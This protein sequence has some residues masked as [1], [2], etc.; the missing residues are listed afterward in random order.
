MIDESMWI[1]P[2]QSLKSGGSGNSRENIE[3]RKKLKIE[4]QKFARSSENLAMKVEKEDEADRVKL[5]V[6]DGNENDHARETAIATVIAKENALDR[7]IDVGQETEIE[8]DLLRKT[9]N[10]G[11][12]GK[13]D[14]PETEED[15]L[16]KFLHC[17]SFFIV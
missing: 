6:T 17:Q 1:S 8:E 5:I 2:N 11:D 4:S 9:E 16:D 14:D 13:E 15:K 10:A 7:E 3:P 12:R